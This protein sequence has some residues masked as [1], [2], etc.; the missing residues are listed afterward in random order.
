VVPACIQGKSKLRPPHSTVLA[1]STPATLIRLATHY[2]SY[3][4]SSMLTIICS[5]TLTPRSKTVLSA[6]AKHKLGAFV[7]HH[8]LRPHRLR[9]Q[10]N[11]NFN[12]R[13][14]HLTVIPPPPQSRVACSLSVCRTGYPYQPQRRRR[15]RNLAL[16]VIPATQPILRQPQQHLQ[17][18]RCEHRRR[19][20]SQKR[21]WS[22]LLDT[23]PSSVC[24]QLHY[25]ACQ[26]SLVASPTRLICRIKL[27][28]QSS[29]VY[30]QLQRP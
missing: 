18:T 8:P 30:E 9:I 3:T 11:R 19:R 14:Q 25:R 20:P 26:V 4:S 28:N 15:R 5:V 29:W 7:Q 17:C 1:R 12:Q 23:S 16:H 10:S 22:R 24:L 27:V 13:M 6:V 2:R 21:I